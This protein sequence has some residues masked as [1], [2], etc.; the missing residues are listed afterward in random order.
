VY[1]GLDPGTPRVDLSLVLSFALP[2][3]LYISEPAPPNRTLLRTA[4]AYN[5]LARQIE[6]HTHYWVLG[7]DVSIETNAWD[8]G[9]AAV[10]PGW[11][12]IA[13]ELADQDSH[14]DFPIFTWEHLERL[15]TLFHPRQWGWGADHWV[16]QVYRQADRVRATG[17]K[18]KHAPTDPDRQQAIAELQPDPPDRSVT[19]SWIRAI[20]ERRPAA[21]PACLSRPV[22]RT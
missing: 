2:Q 14:C 4:P 20:N 1:V 15:G 22:T 3:S 11:L 9:I 8:S 10:P 12:G 21:G 16:Y 5:W 13:G 17:I 7:D 6:P 18:L 19:L